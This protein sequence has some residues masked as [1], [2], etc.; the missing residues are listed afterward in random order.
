MKK[1]NNEISH[2]ILAAS[3]VKVAYVL[4]CQFI[5]LLIFV[6]GFSTIKYISNLL[7]SLGPLTQY[8]NRTLN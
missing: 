7:G 4:L 8:T 6:F 3:R 2:S 1:V 5:Y